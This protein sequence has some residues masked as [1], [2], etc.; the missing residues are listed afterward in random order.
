MRAASVIAAIV[1]LF[2]AVFCFLG[3]AGESLPYQDP[4]PAMLSAQAEAIRAWQFGLGV[5]ALLSA[6]G[7]VGFIRGRASRAAG[8]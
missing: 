7:L 4:T 3:L 1:G 8:R 2:S 6:A 5:S